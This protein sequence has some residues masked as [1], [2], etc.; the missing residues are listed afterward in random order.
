MDPVADIPGLLPLWQSVSGGDPAIRIAIIDGPVDFAHPALRHAHLTADGE[1]PPAG[2]AV[3]SEHGTHVAS[4]IMGTP[5]SAVLGIAPNCTA[6]VYSIYRENE[7]GGLEPTSQAAVALAINRALADGA[8]IINVSSGEQTGTGQ[9]HRILADVVGHCAK[10]GK[11]IVAAAGN[12]GCRCLHVPAALQSVLAVGACDLAGEPLPF[13]NFG[14][15]YL[16]NGILAPGAEVKGASVQQ[17]VALRSGTS[18]ATPIVTGV[19]ALLLSL[20]RQRGEDAD[21]RAIRAALLAS[22][23][24][25]SQH[26]QTSGVRCLAGRLDVSAAVANLL[27]GA[28]AGDSAAAPQ[29]RDRRASGAVLASQFHREFAPA[30]RSPMPP[31]LAREATMGELPLRA[32]VPAAVVAGAQRNAVAASAGI[33]PSEA[34][35]PEAAAAAAVQASALGDEVRPAALA[36]APS[37]S[38]V[39]SSA[40]QGIAATASPAAP[41]APAAAMALG[42]GQRAGGLRPSA[43]DCQCGGI[44]PSQMAAEQMAFPIGRLYYDFGL[45]ARLDYFVQ[46][47]ASWRD[48]LTSRGDPTFGPNRSRAGDTAAPY[49]PEIMARYLWDMA[50]GE[51]G[52]AS[53]NG[54][55]RD[56]DAI[57]WTL[58]IDTTP[59]YAIKPIDVFGL[60]FYAQLVTNLWFQ[61]V[62][63]SPPNKFAKLTT[64]ADA[65]TKSVDD[66]PPKG[67]IA[68]VSLAGWADGGTTR[69]L[70]GTVLPSLRTDWRGFYAWNV[71][72]LLGADPTHWPAGAQEFLQRIYNEFRNVGIS[73]QDRALNYSAMNAFN[74]NAIFSEIAGQ[75]KRLDSVE[76]DRSVIC[77]PN[78]DCWDVTYR[79][80]DP[81]QVLTQARKVYQ[82]TI[83][84]SDVVPVAV[85]PL[86]KWDVY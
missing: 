43:G 42:Y 61:E 27:G 83:D 69:L 75:G 17:S 29:P 15:M 79:F 63:S 52:P 68:R 85:G 25:C 45:E 72:D 38:P 14:E 37:P 49:N 40:P 64:P 9:A 34:V 86:R 73:P 84:V 44:R 57:I 80:F 22:A 35:P 30:A 74:T 54:N 24:P 70:N 65:G 13:S 48:R 59:I 41:P 47:I 18:F 36:P 10:L 58:T 12:D 23:A 5:D 82:Y 32:A 6:T 77:R 21:P 31:S 53:S 56:A 2:A 16:D 8:D 33:T 19:S 55:F 28:D 39:A 76:V 20:L 51:D 46:A 26:A 1:P 50:P 62:S 3:R 11:L 67:S 4:I 60:P 71:Y 7:R 66:W 81:V 78:S